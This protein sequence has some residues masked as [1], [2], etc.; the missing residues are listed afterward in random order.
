MT[1]QEEIQEF[2]HLLNALAKKYNVNLG[3]SI[4]DLT[5]KD[6]QELPE[7]K[8]TKESKETDNKDQLNT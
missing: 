2:N 8:E 5:I 6:N 7:T 4:I 3:V 1:R